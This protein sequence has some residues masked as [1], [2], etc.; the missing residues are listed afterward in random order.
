MANPD[1]AKLESIAREG[2]AQIIR[3]LTHAG[4][5]HPGGSLSVID[6]LTTLF[7]N[8]L[9]YDPKRPQW[10]DRDRFVLSK[11]H[12]VPAQ[13]YCMARAGFFP[14]DRLITLRKLGSP[15]QGHPDRVMLP[16]IEAAT[17]SLGQGL[18]VAMGM[19]LGG[20]LAGKTFRVYCVLGDGEIQEGQVWESL[21][22]AP[23]LGAPDHQLDNLCVILDYNGIQLDNFVKKILD[24][25]PVTDKLKAFGWPVL[26]VNGHD[27][28][29]V[30][31]ALDQAE[32]TR[33]GPTFV[34]AHTVK[35]K[36]VSFMENDPEW[37]GKAPKPEEAVRAVREIAG[38]PVPAWTGPIVAELEA[39]GKK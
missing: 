36:G 23:K 5:G 24:L 15:L 28:A 32:A 10:E 29:Q 30:D 4:S 11:G 31:K 34:V 22:S 18:S 38:T 6:I 16:G 9:R 17:G 7:F 12:C 27:I 39:L 19:A 20:K 21:M 3:M 37:H 8:R 2:R 13:Y 14:M 33:G 1:L 25:E 35:G 26:E